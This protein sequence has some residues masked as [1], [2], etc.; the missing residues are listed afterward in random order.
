MTPVP[1]VA[2]TEFVSEHYDAVARVLLLTGIAAALE[3]IYVFCP[4]M[5]TP[6]DVT[7]AVLESN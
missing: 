4:A 1:D 6:F 5:I 2:A 7:N 3:L